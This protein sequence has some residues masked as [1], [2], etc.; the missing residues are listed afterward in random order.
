METD[1]YQQLMIARQRVYDLLRCFFLLEPTVNFL[2]ALQE[3]DVLKNLRGYHF[4]L[5]EGVELL[6]GVLAA[7]DFGRFASDLLEEYTRL[8][9][10]PSP[11][12]LY[13]SL[14]RSENGL[15]MQEETLAVRRQYIEAGLAVN[16][17]HSFP[18]DHI[19][20]ELEFVFFLCQK[21]AQAK[22]G[23]E[24]D[25]LV[26]MQYRF[27]QEHL[28]KWISPL[29]DRLYQ[30]AESSYFKGLAKLTKGFIL[31]DYQEI[32]SHLSD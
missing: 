26:Q 11:I 7:S 23:Q 14:Y 3:E 12:P 13:E 8:F 28:I 18:E 20:A 29:C 22:E 32:V 24:R 21:A 30:E 5:D 2:K 19:G 4:E 31:W 6:A 25:F 15:L 9:V 1:E 10:G 17:E 27:F 16:P